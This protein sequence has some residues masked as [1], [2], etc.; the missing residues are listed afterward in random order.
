[1][2]DPYWRLQKIIPRVE[3]NVHDSSFLICLFSRSDRVSWLPPGHPK[4]QLLEPAS[5]VREILQSEIHA[6]DDNDD[7]EM[8][9]DSDLVSLIKGSL[10][11][12]LC[13]LS[14]NLHLNSH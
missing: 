4:Y 5:R 1:M 6:E 11:M 8:D 10:K 3:F 2:Q 9:L 13:T 7:Q 14:A 12:T